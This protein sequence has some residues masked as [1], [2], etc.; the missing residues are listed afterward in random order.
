MKR[1]FITG[2]TASGKGALAQELA[3]RL[4]AE[5][6]SV[7]SMK[8]YRGMDVGTA[9]PSPELRREIPFH[10][11]DVADPWEDFSAG[12]FLPLALEAV[13]EI[14]GRGRTVIFQ[15]GTPLYLKTLL[16]GLFVGPAADWSMRKQ[17]LEEAGERGL[18][19]LYGELL[20]LDPLAA[21]KIH[22]RDQ[23][24]IVRAL[25][26]IRSTGEKMTE[27][28]KRSKIALEP[29]DFRLFGIAWERAELY[30]RIDRRVELMVEKGLFEETARLLSDPRGLSRTAAQCLGYRQIIEGLRQGEEQGS[31][32]ARIQEDT[33]RFAKQQL[34]WLRRFSIAWL[35]PQEAGRLADQ[36]LRHF[37]KDS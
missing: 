15:G 13:R 18:P 27:L 2:P 30:A 33:R 31:I 9:K 23:R 34:T 32:A 29:A 19:A 24:R 26:I 35:E 21:Q 37:Q 36:V 16:D 10:L 20:R 17:L 25:E 14:E 22:P 4:G 5:I 7:D 12:K 8:V 3:R 1:I 28:W 6:I 11:I